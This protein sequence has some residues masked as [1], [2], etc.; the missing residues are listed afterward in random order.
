MRG[1]PW[2]PALVHFP[3]ACWILATLIDVGGHVVAL[4]AIEGLAWAGVSRLLLEAGVVLALPAIVAGVRDYLRLSEALQSSRELMSH[5]G[6]MGTAWLLFTAVTVWRAQS[7]ASD[8]VPSLPMT[9]LEFAGCACLV[10]GGHFAG[11][12]VFEKMARPRGDP[13]ADR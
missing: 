12:V 7:G 13:R 9:L 6:L 2:H 1:L 8:A 10:A 4:P 3:V 11:I 5:I